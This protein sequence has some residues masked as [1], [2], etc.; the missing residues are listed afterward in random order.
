M[1]G[2]AGVCFDDAVGDHES[3]LHRRGGDAVFVGRAAVVVFGH[4]YHRVRS[5]AVVSAGVMSLFTMVAIY[6][7]TM[8]FYYGQSR[9]EMWYSGHLLNGRAGNRR[10][11][12]KVWPHSRKDGFESERRNRRAIG[13]MGYAGMNFAALLGICML[14]H[15]ELF[16][17][18]P[19]PRYLTGYYLMI[20]AGGA[21]GGVAV[22][23]LA[24]QC[25]ST[26]FEWNLA[27]FFGLS[28]R[29]G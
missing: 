17:L 23:L 27:L 5:S 24:P 20:S 4:V 13:F 25:L 9:S 16:R 2:V 21:L 14:C 6:T 10:V 19:H 15:G 28:C 29:A 8:V 12:T 22:S 3:R 11:S 1:A 18:R 7:V 26:F